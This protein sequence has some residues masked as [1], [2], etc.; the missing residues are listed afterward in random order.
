MKIVILLGA[1]GCGKGTMAG[2]LSASNPI[3]HHVSSGD[4][5][6]TAV[7][8]KTVYGLEADGFMK[9]GELVPDA[10]IAQMIADYMAA[11]SDECT[12]LLD[13]FPRTLIQA[14]MLEKA[15][16]G[17][18]A[19]LTHVVLLDVPEPILIDRIA[20]RRVCP[21]CGAGYHVVTIPP[22]V[23]G[24]CDM[25]GTTLVT[26]K[27]DNP[28]TVKHRLDVY[29]AQTLPLIAYYEAH[30]LLTQITAH[31]VPINDIVEK[32]RHVIS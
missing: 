21:A 16:A 4:L 20:G 31:G 26:R 12:L 29:Q 7:K 22:K 5:L 6:R 3:F 14:E 23:A 25:C 17:S 24:V 1:P 13:G 32:L 2:R 11:L 27:D 18:R 15:L 10:L 8:N 19:A 30:G 28:E 9:R